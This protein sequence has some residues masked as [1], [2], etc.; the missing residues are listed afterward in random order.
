MILA[1]ISFLGTTVGGK[2]FGMISDALSERR[3]HKHEEAERKH[4]QRLAELDKSQEYMEAANVPQSDGSY[5]PM[6]YISA[7]SLGLFATVYCVAT[8]SCFLW[9]PSSII[10][11]KDP[12][13]DTNAFE[14]LFGLIKWDLA[15]DRV[16]TMSKAGLGFLL[17]QPIV[18]ILSMVFTGDKAR[19]RQ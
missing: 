9:E 13:E 11:T 15:N 4:K 16:I 6:S 5:S 10:Y 1:L 19:K 7:Y 18:F 3:V 2:V 12:T 8:L 14:L 17:L